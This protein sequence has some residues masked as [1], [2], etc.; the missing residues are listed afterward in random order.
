MEAVFYENQKTLVT[1]ISPD[2]IVVGESDKLQ[3][4]IYILLDNAGKYTPKK[5]TITVSLQSEGDKAVLRVSNTGEGIASD[6]LKKIF[7]RF[8]R[9]DK[10]RS[11]ESGGF[12]LGLSIAKTIVESQGGSIGAN[13]ENG[14][15]VFT[16]KLKQ[17]KNN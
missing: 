6:D 8:Y 14:L 3:S 16:V 9:S 2:I 12:G 7:E 10:S 11:S 13:S 5:G 1:E 17:K 15:T 4:V